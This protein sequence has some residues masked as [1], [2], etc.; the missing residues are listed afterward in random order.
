MGRLLT[1]LLLTG[2][3]VVAP[4]IRVLCYGSCAP[5]AIATAETA[6]ASDATPSCHEPD[7]SHHSMPKPDNS[8]LPGDCT[9]GGESSLSSL[10]ASATQL[11]G[12]DGP[13]VPLVSTI[14]SAHLLVVPSDVRW[15]TPPGLSFLHVSQETGDGHCGPS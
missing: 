1:H 14:P 12:S 8:P 2:A 9:H 4:V 7:K 5:D 15:D 13:R 11:V 6:S 10:K 3:L